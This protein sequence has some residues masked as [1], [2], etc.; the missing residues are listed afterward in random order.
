MTW[1]RYVFKN[2]M[3]H[4][5]PVELEI[6]LV[7]EM[8]ARGAEL[9][10]YTGHD[11]TNPATIDSWGFDIGGIC[12]LHRPIE[13]FTWSGLSIE[14]P[15]EDVSHFASRLE[16]LEQRRFACG[17]EYR[18][19]KVWHHCTVMT[20]AQAE[21]LRLLLASRLAEADG[22]VRLFRDA[23]RRADVQGGVS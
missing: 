10:D 22:R 3:T 18:K 15:S 2:F 1:R 20:P 13:S 8:T 6:P 9:S 16:W 19:L 5:V 4:V 14:V 17:A 7:V 12:H 11:I 21:S 23:I